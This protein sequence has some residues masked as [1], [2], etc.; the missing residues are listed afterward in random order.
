[1]QIK[2]CGEQAVIVDIT[3]E[4]TKQ[5][6]LDV[7]RTVL[8][9]RDIVDS[10]EL[11]GVVD[12]VPAARTLLIMVDASLLSPKDLA[13]RVS[14]CDLSVGSQDEGAAAEEIEISVRYDG[15]DLAEIA[16][17]LGMSVSAL[18]AKH[19]ATRWTAAFGG[20]APGFAYLVA[21]EPLG[22]APRLASPRPSIPTGSVGLAG[23]FSGIYPQA[24]PGGWQIIGST[25]ASL[26]D[27]DRAD[28]PALIRPGDHVRFKEV[29]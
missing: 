20:F 29:N 13:Q 15:P 19:Q 14:R 23:E 22:N 1:M 11:S 18:V 4:D 16:Q 6:G 2:P 24:S 21:D 25:D 26:W 12:L 8:R 27:V 17:I 10:W 28:R 7:L 3:E 9:L 5:T